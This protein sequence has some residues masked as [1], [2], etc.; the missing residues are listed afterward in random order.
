VRD[1][2]SI[3]TAGNNAAI[4][5]D[6][7]TKQPP[8]YK[9][10]KVKERYLDSQCDRIRHCGFEEL[11]LHV[12]G[13]YDLSESDCG[14]YISSTKTINI[15][16]SSNIKGTSWTHDP[17]LGSP[18]VQCNPSVGG[19][20]RGVGGVPSSRFPN[21]DTLGNLLIIQNP[22]VTSR[23]NDDAG[24]CIFFDYSPLITDELFFYEYS[25]FDLGLLD[26]EEGATITVRYSS[27]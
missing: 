24:G 25:I 21:C 15:F 13:P 20:G 6:I 23:P 18:N 5:D 1:F 19:P 8:V 22:K 9:E 27:F 26:I 11:T 10:I 12:F 7:K 14:F 17:D 3:E 2:L 4:L 16:N